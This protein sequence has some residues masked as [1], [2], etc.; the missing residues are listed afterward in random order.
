ME[1]KKCERCGCFYLSDNSVCENCIPKDNKEINQLKNFFETSNEIDSINS[2]CINTG[3]SEKNI[4][5]Y[6]QNPEF[7]KFANNISNNNIG[8]ITLG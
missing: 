5:R 6:L 4:N 8:N 3:I 7:S 1:F 2:I